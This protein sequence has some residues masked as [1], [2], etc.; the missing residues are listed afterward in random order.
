MS[1]NY[2]D[3]RIK[4]IFDEAATLV[5]GGA[6]D[7]EGLSEQLL[8]VAAAN[9]PAVADYWR[10]TQ[11][12][13]GVPDTAFKGTSPYL[14]PDEPPART[15]R[16][17]GTSGTA[18]GVAHYSAR[19]MELMDLSIL[20]GARANVVRGLDR[21]M[22]LRLVPPEQLAPEM[23][24]AHGMELIARELGHP[25]LSAC[26]VT[27]SGVDL[28]LLCSRL[29]VAVAEGIP[30][31]L[32]GG[33]FAFVNVCDALEAQKRSWSLAAGSRMIDAGGFKGRSRVASVEGLRSAA[34]RVF[35]IA[36]GANTNLFGMTEL[37]SQLYDAA[38][39]AVGPLGERPKGRT[40]YVQPRVRDAQTLARRDA[41]VGLLEV[42][43]L[44]IIDRPHVVLTGDRGIA[45]PEGVAIAGR[46]ERGQSRGCS[47]TL[48]AMTGGN[49]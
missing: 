45:R 22:I 5:T 36:P 14:F 1:V 25:T 23:V 7:A 43:D 42:V 15:F 30:V 9:L 28:P 21:P 49:S 4:R 11:R 39:I 34:A 32:I 3:S 48:D 44:C 40:A 27:P 18:K 2:R 33:S 47:L 29:D 16:T 17:S 24:M 38:D 26:V 35:G 31:V 20:A 41:G 12:G 6:G 37:A 13:F 10:R 8:E 46:I 19:G